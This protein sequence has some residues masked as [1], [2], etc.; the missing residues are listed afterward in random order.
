MS[1]KYDLLE[2]KFA[3]KVTKEFPEVIKIF[4]KFR[5]E[6]RPYDKFVSVQSV[7]DSIDQS[8]ESVFS[9]MSYYK[10]VVENKGEKHE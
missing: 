6:L 9:N 8:A 4:E 5:K 3:S 10:H 7:I 2:Y 1:K